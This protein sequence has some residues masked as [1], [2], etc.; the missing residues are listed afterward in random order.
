MLKITSLGQVMLEEGPPKWK[1]MLNTYVHIFS[2]LGSD[3]N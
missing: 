2:L 3:I 1:A